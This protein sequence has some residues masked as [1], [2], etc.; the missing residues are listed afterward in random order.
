M[1]IK[2]TVASILIFA[3][4]FMLCGCDFFTVDTEN[5]LSPPVLS[6][7]LAAIKEIID[8]TAPEGY[9]LK[10]PSS[11]ERRSAVIME[12]IDS[13]GVLEAFAF[14]STADSETV[15]MHIDL[16]KNLGGK[17][18]LAAGQTVP[19]SGIDRIEFCDLDGDGKKEILAGCELYGKSAKELG[20][21]SISGAEFVTRFTKPY[22]VFVCCDLDE[23]GR[24]EVFVQL[25]NTADLLNSASLCTLTEEGVSQISCA[26][27]GGAKTVSEPYLSVLSSGE[28][29]VYIDEIKGIGAVTEVISFSKGALVNKLLDTTAA[30]PVNS[31]TLRASTLSVTDINGDGIPEIPVASELPSAANETN[32]LLYY[33][34]WC[35][36][37]GELLTVK[38]VTIMNSVDGYFIT[39]PQKW[40]GRISVFKDTDAR[41]RNFYEYDSE[42][43]AV[44]KKLASFKAVDEDDYKKSDYKNYTE[45]SRSGGLVYLGAESSEESELSVTGEEIKNMFTLL[46]DNTAKR[47]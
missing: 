15:F 9:V 22:T 12:D 38:Q 45:L 23:N 35:T 6:G 27:D 32:E 30:V 33:T 19:A 18:E 31:A 16:I 11:G 20:V 10:Y 21:Y 24:N 44:G 40:V 17:W 34:N 41:V 4:C 5:L 39:V 36:F 47:R 2:K 13:D 1:R 43:G 28:P 26:M 14:Y 37:N 3:L 25:L 29:A 8:K 7:D 42:L 46:N